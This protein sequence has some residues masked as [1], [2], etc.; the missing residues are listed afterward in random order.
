MKGLTPLPQ[1][2]YTLAQICTSFPGQAWVVTCTLLG[3]P[4][5]LPASLCL[6]ID[7]PGH[8][9]EQRATLIYPV[10]LKT[11]SHPEYIIDVRNSKLRSEVLT[12]K[13]KAFQP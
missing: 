11:M 3:Q 5:T 8:R 1:N 10:Y 4:S 6:H 13:K 7:I 2:L 12:F 9:P